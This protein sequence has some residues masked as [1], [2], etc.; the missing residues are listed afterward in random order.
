M[1]ITSVSQASEVDLSMRP[2]D[3]MFA[4]FRENR[5]LASDLSYEPLHQTH[6]REQTT[7]D[8]PT[9]R[10]REA[11]VLSVGHSRLRAA[12]EIDISIGSH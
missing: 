12:D 8:R 2:S 11:G 5:Q 4:V 6:S 7:S 10:V 3:V 9:I 1:G